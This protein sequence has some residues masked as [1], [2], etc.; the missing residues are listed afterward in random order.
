MLVKEILAKKHGKIITISP[1]AKMSN[2][3]RIMAT[4]KIGTIL[5]V[6]RDDQPKGIFSEHDL[7]C[8]TATHGA[9]AREFPVGELASSS[10]ITCTE[11]NAL[12]DV[13]TLVSNN[14]IRHL[15]VTRDQRLVGM[16]SAR[17]LMDAQKD[18]LLAALTRQKQASALMGRTKNQAEQA[19]RT[20]TG[21]LSRMRHELRTPLNSIIGFSDIIQSQNLG[22]IANR[23]YVDYACKIHKLGSHFLALIDDILSLTRL[24]NGKH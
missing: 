1:D 20:K 19:N 3:V 12:E 9:E 15:P 6:D 13:L 21:F 24:E 18:Y 10:V 4:R 16:I 8:M 7:V 2:A 22:N 17:N 14:R 23:N 5:L 11:E